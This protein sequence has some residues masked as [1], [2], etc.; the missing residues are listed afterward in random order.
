MRRRTLASTC[1]GGM[2][3]LHLAVRIGRLHMCM[4]EGDSGGHY[5]RV[6]DSTALLREGV[7]SSAPFV[8]GLVVWQGVT[9]IPLSAACFF[10]CKMV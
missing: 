2:T 3:R 8:L 5:S 1:V 7:A 6:T 9:D 10:L 4:G